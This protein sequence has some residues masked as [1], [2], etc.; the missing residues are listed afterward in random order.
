MREIGPLALI[1]IIPG[2]EIISKLNN[3]YIFMNTYER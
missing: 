1:A 3:R 2:E